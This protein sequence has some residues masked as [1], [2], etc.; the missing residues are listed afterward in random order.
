MGKFSLSAIA[1]FFT[2]LLL[3]EYTVKF[4]ETPSWVKLAYL[5]LAYIVYVIFFGFIYTHSDKSFQELYVNAF[6]LIFCVIFNEIMT[7]L[8]ASRHLSGELLRDIG[9]EYI[10]ELDESNILV[11]LGDVFSVVPVYGLFVLALRLNIKEIVALGNST[12][13]E[14]AVFFL[15]RGACIAVTSL[16]GPARHCR[17]GA[18]Y[19]FAA[20]GFDIVA[21]MPFSH[22]MS[23]KTCGDLVPSGHIAC[24]VFS[25]FAFLKCLD[26][27][28]Y[29]YRRLI[30]VFCWLYMFFVIYLLIADRRH[31]SVDIVVGI[32]LSV[33][34]S[35]I[36]R[37]GWIP[38]DSPVEPL[39]ITVENQEK[40]KEDSILVEQEQNNHNKTE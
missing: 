6:I 32:A 22:G 12:I 18:G 16:P 20:S 31:Y 7:N 26:K 3:W 21:T 4:I 1:L 30:Y 39:Y 23:F 34:V 2:T 29:T 8:A 35:I 28:L 9:F 37:D 17:I 27:K 14:F 11:K 25:L 38:K 40:Q 24:V 19:T 10:P 33:C 36:F 13:R 5:A 15:I